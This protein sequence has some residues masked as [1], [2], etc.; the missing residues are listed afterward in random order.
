GFTRARAVLLAVRS[1]K[2]VKARRVLFEDALPRRFRQ[3]RT[4]IEHFP[5]DP[6]ERAVE[7]GVVGAPQDVALGAELDHRRQRLLVGI[8]RNEALLE[9]ILTWLA[10]EPRHVPPHLLVVAIHAVEPVSDPAHARLEEAHSQPG[11][12]LE[13]SAAHDVHASR[14]QLEGMADH[15][16]EEG[17]SI[18]VGAESRHAR[19][20]ARMDG[21]RDVEVLRFTPERIVGGIVE[22][23]AIEWIRSHEDGLEAEIADHAVHFP[24]RLLDTLD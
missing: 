11:K 6:R 15:V 5:D 19:S 8:E 21:H 13:H 10:P 2:T 14:L 22:P 20:E 16:K 3:R 4:G 18:T 7:M 23:A 17:I 24:D 9:E 1:G 12:L